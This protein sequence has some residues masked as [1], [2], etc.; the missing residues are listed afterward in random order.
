MGVDIER[1]EIAQTAAGGAA[2]VD[3]DLGEGVGCGGV[4]AAGLGGWR[5]WGGGGG[6]ESPLGLGLGG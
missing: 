5:G 2:G 3:V 6:E 4:V 1:P